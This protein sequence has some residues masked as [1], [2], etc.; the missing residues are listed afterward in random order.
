M[1]RLTYKDLEIGQEV[2][3]QQY[4][5]RLTDNHYNGVVTNMDGQNIVVEVLGHAINEPIVDGCEIN[6]RAFE[7]CN[8]EYAIVTPFIQ[9]E[10]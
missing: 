3:V 5:G 8:P 9:E 7:A 4:Y 1:S 6:I 10:F 2:Q